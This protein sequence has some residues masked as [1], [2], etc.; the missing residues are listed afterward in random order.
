MRCQDADGSDLQSILY[1]SL[2]LVSLHM[3]LACTECL[4]IEVNRLTAVPCALLL[5]SIQSACFAL[6][7]FMHC[8]FGRLK[9][10]KHLFAETLC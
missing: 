7:A 8:T 5:S 4:E 3:V 10:Q 1:L 9:H 2:R 6:A